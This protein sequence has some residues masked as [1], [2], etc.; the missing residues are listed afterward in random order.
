MLLLLLNDLFKLSGISRRLPTSACFV[1]VL[2][3]VNRCIRMTC[4]HFST[5]IQNLG[6]AVL[7]IAFVD[8]SNIGLAL[9]SVTN[10]KTEHAGEYVHA[11]SSFGAILPSTTPTPTALS[12]T[13][14]IVLPH[15]S[16]GKLLQ[17]YCTMKSLLLQSQEKLPS[18]QLKYTAL[19]FSSLYI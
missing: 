18:V 17:Q 11:R 1:Q 8:F 13:S 12:E 3:C 7:R 2:Q 5:R 9:S 4:A 15:S 6:I 19:V 14:S 16:S 10:C